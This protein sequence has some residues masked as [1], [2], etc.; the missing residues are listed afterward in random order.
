MK[1]ELR[2]IGKAVEAQHKAEGHVA[3]FYLGLYASITCNRP[4]CK[5]YAE[6]VRT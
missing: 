6:L 5:A 3:T 1:D 4:A 2:I